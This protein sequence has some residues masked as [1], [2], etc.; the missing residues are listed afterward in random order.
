VSTPIIP[1][2]Q[3]LRALGSVVR[4]AGTEKQPTDGISTVSFDDLLAKARSGELRSDVPV[5]IAPGSGVELTDEQLSKVALAADRAQAQGVSRAVVSIDGMLLRLD[6]GVRTITGVI[7]PGESGVHTGID[8]LITFAPEGKEPTLDLRG[9]AR[10]G[11][12]LAGV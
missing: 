11:L 7:E 2:V 6:V 4:P 8:G 9:L 5:T 1:A 10:A 12:R 3:L